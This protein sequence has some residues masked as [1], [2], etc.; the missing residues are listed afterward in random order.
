[1]RVLLVFQL[2]LVHKNV[3]NFTPFGFQQYLKIP[4]MV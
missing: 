4:F 3:A 2:S 1:M